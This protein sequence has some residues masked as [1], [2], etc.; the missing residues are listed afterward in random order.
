MPKGMDMTPGQWVDEAGGSF[1][2]EEMQTFVNEWYPTNDGVEFDDARSRY[3]TNNQRRFVE[4]ALAIRKERDKALTVAAQEREVQVTKDIF[5]EMMGAFGR[6][7]EIMQ[8]NIPEDEK[9]SEIG[10][11]IHVASGLLDIQTEKGD[12]DEEYNC[13]T[14]GFYPYPKVNITNNLAW[15]IKTSIKAIDLVTDKGE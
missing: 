1:T 11:I 14:G 13:V 12:Y 3:K 6:V 10:Y 4:D 15:C 9:G 8:Q 2:A 7:C 5:S